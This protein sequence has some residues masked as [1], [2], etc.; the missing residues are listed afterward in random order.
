MI[1]ENNLY[2]FYS[3]GTPDWPPCD[4]CHAGG[5]TGD[6]I[7][8]KSTVA[9]DNFVSAGLFCIYRE[10]ILINTLPNNNQRR[11]QCSSKKRYHT[12]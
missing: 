6:E 11:Q 7:S 3:G 5:I 10:K 1:G 2:R 4:A 12:N 8:P 9:D